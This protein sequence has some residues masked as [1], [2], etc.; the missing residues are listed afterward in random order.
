MTPALKEIERKI[1]DYMVHYLREN[2][3]QPSIREI[4]EH[5]GIKS[6]KTVSEHLQALARKGRLERDPSRSRG[7]RILDVDL[8][9]DAVSLPCYEDLPDDG[10]AASGSEGVHLTLDRRLAG[11]KGAFLV[12]ARGDELAAIGVEEGDF[13]LLEPA[14]PS[15]VSDGSVVA[16]RGSPTGTRFAR[17][18]RNGRGLTLRALEGG[19]AAVSVE[20]PSK[21]E[22]VGRV[23]G[24]FRRLDGSTTAMS[25]TAH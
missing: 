6:T 18:G 17:V 7:V 1:L 8:H 15:E 14:V 19:S 22:I 2:T 20:D 4:G 25:L 9:P 11:G 24:L 21:L 23:A 12:R 10:L 3:Y 16:L 13:L 5:F